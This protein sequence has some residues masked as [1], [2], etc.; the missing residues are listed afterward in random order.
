ML[1]GSRVRLH[2]GTVCRVQRADDEAID[3]T[4][5]TIETFDSITCRWRVRLEG[6]ELMLAEDQLELV[7][8][9]LP[10]SLDQ[11]EI[12]HELAFE[13]AQGSCGRGLIIKQHVRAGSLLFQE[14]PFVVVKSSV[15]EMETHHTARWLAYAALLGQ[16][17]HEAAARSSDT[18]AVA[19]VS[20]PAFP[21]S[22][23]TCRNSTCFTRAVFHTCCVSH[24]P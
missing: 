23:A 20:P 4:L 17:Q 21:M 7:Y 3:G 2:V 9:L 13:D 10:A 11:N 6:K 12:Y 1:Q 5:C 16:R 14:P 18:W 24:V 8:S 19:T 15:C 22:H